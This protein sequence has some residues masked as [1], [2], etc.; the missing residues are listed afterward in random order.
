MQGEIPETIDPHFMAERGR[1]FVGKMSLQKMDRLAEALVENIGGVDYELE[2]VKEGKTSAIKG[3]IQAVLMLECQVC[4]GR[5]EFVVDTVLNLAAVVSLDESAQLTDCYEPLIVTEGK[6]V[7]KD[8]IEDELLLALPIIP[9]HPGC[10]VERTPIKK[11]EE[12]QNPFAVLAD[13]K[14]KGD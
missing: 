12:T 6:S 9:R 8:I 5:M 2:F 11:A 7:A 1:C 13:L 4:L 14:F 10:Q 3:R